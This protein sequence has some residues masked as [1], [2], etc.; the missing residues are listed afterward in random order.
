MRELVLMPYTYFSLR[1][2]IPVVLFGFP[3]VPVRIFNFNW[4][5]LLFKKFRILAFIKGKS[6]IP[7]N[8]SITLETRSWNS[9]MV[10]QLA[11]LIAHTSTGLIV[12]WLTCVICHTFDSALCIIIRPT[13]I[14]SV[15]SQGK[16][17]QNKVG[18]RDLVVV[19]D[20]LVIV[21]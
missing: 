1:T 12:A 7:K 5:L 11:S 9:R 13:C 16:I 20:Y 18:E 10:I 2:L 8:L 4:V 14:K 17:Y 3:R 6:R 19:V 15:T 21:Y